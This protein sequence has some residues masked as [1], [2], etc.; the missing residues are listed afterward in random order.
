M[1]EVTSE[2]V[3]VCGGY[4]RT[5]QRMSNNGDFISVKRTLYNEGEATCFIN[6]PFDLITTTNISKRNFLQIEY[7]SNLSPH[8]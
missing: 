3:C 2:E 5:S 6:S 1:E 4:S 7:L 8:A